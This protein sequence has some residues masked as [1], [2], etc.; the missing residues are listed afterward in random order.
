MPT[1]KER[2]D[3]LDTIDC[4]F[5]HQGY[6]DYRYYSDDWYRKQLHRSVRDVIDSA[7]ADAQKSLSPPLNQES[8]NG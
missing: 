5:C 6:G 8:G 4:G 2:L 7:M 1:D 3:F